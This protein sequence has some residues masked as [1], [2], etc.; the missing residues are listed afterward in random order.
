MSIELVDHKIGKK[1]FD[2]FN[3][4]GYYTGVSI[5]RAYA[6]KERLSK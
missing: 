4:I 6:H 1:T 3:V 2:K 5:N